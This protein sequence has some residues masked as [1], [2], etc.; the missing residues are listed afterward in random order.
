M[1]TL[2]G[3]VLQTHSALPCEVWSFLDGYDYVYISNVSFS[4][5]QEKQDME[6]LGNDAVNKVHA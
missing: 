5:A 6:G 1:E 2:R 4:S 3:H